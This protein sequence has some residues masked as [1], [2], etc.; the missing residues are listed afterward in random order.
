MS[1]LDAVKAIKDEGNARF[2]AKEYEAAIGHYDRAIKQLASDEGS[3][4]ADG[5]PELLSILHSNT[6][7]C[8]I[9]QGEWNLARKSAKTAVR[10]DGNNAKA[11]MRLETAEAKLME[12]LSGIERE[13]RENSI[14]ETCAIQ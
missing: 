10:L 9:F 7:Q 5:A 11:Q 14:K 1:S 8:H 2:P 3:S 4:S 6:A 13:A 12:K